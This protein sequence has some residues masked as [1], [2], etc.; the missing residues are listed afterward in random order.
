MTTVLLTGG[1]GTF[2]RAFLASVLP[3]G[4]TVRVF[5]RDEFKQGEVRREFQEHADNVR[6]LIGDV[7]DPERLRHAAAGCDLIVHAAALK[8]VVS[9][10]YNPYEAVLTNVLG[11]RN[12]LEAALH[13][14]VPRSVLLSSDKA[15]HPVNLYGATKLC[16]EKLWLSP[17][18]GGRPERFALVRYG[19]VTGSRGSVLAEWDNLRL[20]RP[21]TITDALATRFWLSGTEAVDLV[22]LA[23]NH[24]HGG[25][26]FVPKVMSSTIGSL[27][28]EG[29][30]VET[31]GLQRGEKLHERLLSDEE[32]PRTWDCGSHYRVC[33]YKPEGATLVPSDFE[34]VSSA[35]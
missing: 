26:I 1:T 21:L 33:D 11:S 15:V 17:E 6:F 20:Y 13:N 35:A 8:Q 32:I 4:W 5:S 14:R 9:C 23:A 2:G 22:L 12:V 3:L 34:Y 10:E 31:I 25:E 29:A 30:T 16:A 19:N 28:P 18:H 24:M 27:V 7:R